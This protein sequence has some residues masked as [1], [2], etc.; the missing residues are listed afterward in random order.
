M[1]LAERDL[2]V[3]R[4][5]T[6]TAGSTEYSSSPAASTHSLTTRDTVRI[7]SP[8]ILDFK[9]LRFALLQS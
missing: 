3:A 4:E 6:E 9:R 7:A 2:D 1:L 8:A 5:L